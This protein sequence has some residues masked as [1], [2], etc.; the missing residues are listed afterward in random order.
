MMGGTGRDRKRSR[1]LYVFGTCL[2]AVVPVAVV[3]A[4]RSIW[5]LCPRFFCLLVVVPLMAF[6]AAAVRRVRDAAGRTR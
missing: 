5:L 6:T 2:L 4:A 1:G 3:L